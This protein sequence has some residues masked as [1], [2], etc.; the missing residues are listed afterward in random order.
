MR[1]TILILS[2]CGLISCGEKTQE[3]GVETT[4]A[5]KPTTRVVRAPAGL[6]F[7]VPTDWQEET[8]SS[9][10]RQ[11]ELVLP[12]G[13]PGDDEARLVVYYFGLGGAGGVQANLDRW[14]GQFETADG[15]PASEAAKTESRTVNSLD[16]TTVELAGRYVA[17][18]QPGSGVRLD[19]PDYRMR[20]AIV[21]TSRGPFF[22]KLVG[23]ETSIDP[24]A[25]EWNALVESI[26]AD[27]V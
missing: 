15:R 27:G 4:H 12:K 9:S 18:T 23:P 16:V 24:Q 11:V 7:Q 25:G 2:L 13:R 20:A 3:S 6:S 22:F 5:A 1:A 17:E 10:M 21:Q 8:P 14:Y 19:R 26:A